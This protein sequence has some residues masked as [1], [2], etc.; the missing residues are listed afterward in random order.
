MPPNFRPYKRGDVIMPTVQFDWDE[1]EDNVDE[2]LDEN[3][4]PTAEYTS[5]PELFGNVISQLRDGVTSTF[6]YEGI[7][8]TIAVTN[9]AG[10]VTDTLQYS[11]FGEV[12]KRMG[13]TVIPYQFIG[14]KGYYFDSVVSGLSVRR[15]VYQP[16]PQRWLSKDPAVNIFDPNAY[17]Y[18]RNDPVDLVDESG[19]FTLEDAKN[20]LC[21]LSLLATSPGVYLACRGSLTSAGIF[22][23][24][25]ALESTSTA[26]LSAVPPCPCTIT[27][28]TGIV[29]GWT[30]P[31]GIP[32]TACLHPNTGWYAGFSQPTID[33][34][35]LKKYHP[36][37]CAEIR[38]AGTNGMSGQQCTYDVFGNLITTAP[39]AGTPD[40]HSPLINGAKHYLHDVAP[41]DL[42]YDLDLRTLT[43]VG[44]NVTSYLTVRPPNNALG[45]P[46]N[47]GL[48]GTATCVRP[49]W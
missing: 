37:A 7:G 14:Q 12:T 35:I 17:R 1:I 6:H 26:W 28:A 18:C 48:G 47:P 25:I 19:L 20:L 11:A 46:P 36:G 3:L 24:W 34:A 10:D 2:E 5:E 9:D 43:P 4:N 22:S 30:C 39:A 40:L 15:R 13:S 44:P 31:S 41:F 32:V 49:P 42:A 23:A 16:V 27:C 33:G 38:S 21:P 8:S 29:K 45:C